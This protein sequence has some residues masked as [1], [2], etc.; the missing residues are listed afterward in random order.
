[1]YEE[2]LGKSELLMEAFHVMSDMREAH[3]PKKAEEIS[4]SKVLKIC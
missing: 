2:L 3:E 4:G 1:M